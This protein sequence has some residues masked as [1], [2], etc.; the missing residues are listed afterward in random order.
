MSR[1]FLIVLCCALLAAC[2]ALA[3][4]E[5]KDCLALSGLEAAKLS[6]IRVMSAIPQDDVQKLTLPMIQAHVQPPTGVSFG[7]GLIFSVVASVIVSSVINSQVQKR[8]EQAT[9]A[10]PPLMEQVKDFDFRRQF[11]SRLERSL[12]D[13]RRFKVLDI[14]TYDSE[15]T[16]AEQPETVGGEPLDALLDLRTEYA[17]T[18][19]LRSF[20]MVTQAVLQTRADNREIYR[21]R[22][23]F[24]TPPVSA[25]EYEAAIAVWAADGGALY[26]A[27]AV[28]GMQQTMKML[29]F[30]LTGDDAPRP[31]GA[32]VQVHESRAAPAGSIIRAPIAGGLVEREDGALIAR[33]AQGFL[34]STIEGETF[35]PT[36][37]VVAAAAQAPAPGAGRGRAG[38]VALDDLL[39][40]L[41]E[42]Q[43]A[44]RKEAEAPKKEAVAPPPESRPTRA[45]LEDLEALLGR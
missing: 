39:G 36:P 42:G 3:Q 41:D 23:H 7:G 27:A 20:M 13:D 34:R 18:P 24:T 17:L 5:R 15:R 12:E 21:C 30:D 44:P 37:E 40:A 4:E 35:S 19:D 25:G 6:N 14:A 11:W 38:P 26:R 29:R 1:R 43:P 22:F 9:L 32:E 10:F 8:I 16:Y 45:G 28:I 2:P 31:S 33:D